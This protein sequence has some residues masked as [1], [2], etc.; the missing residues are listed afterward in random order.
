MGAVVVAAVV[1]TPT[2]RSVSGHGGVRRDG[3]GARARGRT[4]GGRWSGRR[5]RRP[6]RRPRPTA[7]RVLRLPHLA[8]ILRHLDVRRPEVSHLE[9][10]VRVGIRRPVRPAPRVRPAP[11]AVLAEPTPLVVP[12]RPSLTFRVAAP[13]TA[14][15]PGPTTRDLAAP[16]ARATNAPAAPAPHT[17]PNSSAAPRRPCSPMPAPKASKPSTESEASTE[18]S[19]SQTRKGSASAVATPSRSAQRSRLSSSW[20]ITTLRPGLN[21]RQRGGRKRVR[22]PVTRPDFRSRG[23]A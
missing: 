6:P 10:G 2:T 7:T 15:R 20:G 18:T 21:P 16:V 12:R 1:A 14:P 19:V 13:T 17:A 4:A 22:A 3:L 5:T 8:Q 9:V 11:A 23:R